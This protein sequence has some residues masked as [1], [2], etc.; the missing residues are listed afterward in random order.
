MQDP[1]AVVKAYMAAAESGDFQK[2]LA[3]YAED[4]VVKNGLGLFVGKPQI[5][6]WLENDVKTTRSKPSDWKVQG[7]L[8]VTSGQVSLARFQQAGIDS[9]AFRAEYMID[10]AG[11]IRFFAPV[12]T[13]TPDQ[14][15]KMQALQAN[16]PAA[17]TPAQN[18]LEIVKAYVAA[19]NQGDYEQALSYYTED[20]AALVV[21]G[22]LLLSG[23]PQIAGWLKGDVQ[24]TRANPQDWKVN[25][26]TVINTGTVTLERFQKLGIT[27]VQYSAEYVVEK[28][29]IRFFRP[30][31]TLNS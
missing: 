20:A 6:Q 14:Q 7:P 18:P 28:G 5:A 13:L 4:A 27:S 30:S 16:A 31:V 11:K 9:V 24:T 10:P 19:A 26:N 21:N 22:S 25:G 1:I 2:A 17:P 8:V 23:K 3:F 12:V 29:K 15:Q